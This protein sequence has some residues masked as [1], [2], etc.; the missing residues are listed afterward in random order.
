[1]L[2]VLLLNLYNQM[3][4]WTGQYFGSRQVDWV[5]L[6][7][8][9]RARMRFQGRAMGHVS[10]M[11]FAIAVMPALKFSPW[12]RFMVRASFTSPIPAGTRRPSNACVRMQGISFERMLHFHRQLQRPLT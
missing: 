2:T 8:S 3:Q 10:M 12:R 1:M 6:V 5:R 4:F 7:A 11:M 9:A